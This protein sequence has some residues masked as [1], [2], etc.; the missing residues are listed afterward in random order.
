[1]SAPI[2]CANDR[3]E[4]K[5][6]KKI[7]LMIKNPDFI[8]L[9]K[10]GITGV[11]NTAATLIVFTLFNSL[12]PIGKIASSTLGYITGM[13]TSYTINRSWTFN[14][15]NSFLS[16]ELI[17][18]VILNLIVMGIGLITLKICVDKFSMGEYVTQYFIV[19]PLNLILNFIGSRLLVF[20]NTKNK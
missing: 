19:T 4:L 20:K 17:K 13:I 12:T 8:K 9:I 14:T 11:I 1:M 7:Y 18:F 3:M 2:G 16:P 10:F 6:F 5:M 15:K